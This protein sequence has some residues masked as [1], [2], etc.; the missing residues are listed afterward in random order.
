MREA[1]P[2]A[3]LLPA[4]TDQEYKALKADIAAHGILYPVITD[5]SDRVLDGVHRVRIARRA[6]HRAAGLL[7]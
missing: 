7:P 5:E 4:L 6:R 1:H 2:Y 3:L